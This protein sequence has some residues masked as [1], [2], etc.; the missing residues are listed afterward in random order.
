[1]KSI[2]HQKQLTSVLEICDSLNDLQDKVNKRKEKSGILAH[3]YLAIANPTFVKIKPSYLKIPKFEYLYNIQ[4]VNRNGEFKIASTIFSDLDALLSLEDKTD[5]DNK[6]NES[7][8]PVK[9]LEP[10][11]CNINHLKAKRQKL[12]QDLQLVQSL[13]KKKVD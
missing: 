12:I 11:K 13:E 4:T 5:N 6:V 7:W 10:F 1:L 8:L 9:I 3:N 2:E